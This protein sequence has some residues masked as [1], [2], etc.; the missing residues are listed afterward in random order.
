MFKKLLA[1]IAI[2]SIFGTSF[3]PAQAMEQQAL[4]LDKETKEILSKKLPQLQ[5]SLIADADHA[6]FK[7][8]PGSYAQLSNLPNAPK[9]GEILSKIKIVAKDVGIFMATLYGSHL[10]CIICHELGHKVAAKLLLGISGELHFG[11]GGKFGI[12]GGGYNVFRVTQKI[13]QE[14]LKWIYVA[15]AGP[16]A[17]ILGGL[18]IFALT[19]YLKKYE[20]DY[21]RLFLIRLASTANLW[22]NIYSNIG[23]SMPQNDGLVRHPSLRA[24]STDGDQIL[25]HYLMMMSKK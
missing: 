21:P 1:F 19:L 17:G 16:V 14:H 11:I 4:E 15:A 7:A 22:P 3:M 23:C 24:K 8:T 18:G 25:W 2:A 12:F 5:L 13:D 10:I 20:K 6:A 9:K